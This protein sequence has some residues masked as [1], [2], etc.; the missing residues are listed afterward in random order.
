MAF[1]HSISVQDAWRDLREA[2][3]KTCNGATSES[4][5]RHQCTWTRT[6][7]LSLDMLKPTIVNFR[8]ARG[9]ELPVAHLQCTASIHSAAGLLKSSPASNDVERDEI[10]HIAMGMHAASAASSECDACSGLQ[11]GFVADTPDPRSGTVADSDVP[12]PLLSCC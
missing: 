11:E 2:P 5:V 4:P 7:V 3:V 12:A 10:N 9:K 6:C 1:Q 8:P